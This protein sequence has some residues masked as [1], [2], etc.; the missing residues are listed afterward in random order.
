MSSQ[1]PLFPF[2]ALVGQEQLKKALILNAIN[3]RLGGVL[4]RGKK[5]RR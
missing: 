1:H 2:A 5:G 4:I 3:P